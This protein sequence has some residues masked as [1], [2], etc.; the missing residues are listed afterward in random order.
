MNQALVLLRNFSC[1]ALLYI[2]NSIQ[3]TTASPQIK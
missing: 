3:D 2:I 1:V